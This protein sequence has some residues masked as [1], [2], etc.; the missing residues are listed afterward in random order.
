MSVK[1]GWQQFIQLIHNTK[2]DIVELDQLLDFLLT[3]EE[4]TQMA[5]RVILT[6]YL[7]Y[8]DKTQRTI[9]K[10]LEVSLTTITRCSNLLKHTSDEIKQQ[11]DFDLEE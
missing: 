10:E 5:K 3:D 11:F 1:F 4:K 7:I 9:A 8:S 2:N 6:N